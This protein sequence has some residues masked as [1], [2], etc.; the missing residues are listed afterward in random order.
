MRVIAAAAAVLIM[1]GVADARTWRVR[2]GPEAEQELQTALIEARPGDTVQLGRGRIELTSGLS[3]D[4]DRVTIRGEGHDETILSFSN[5][6]RGAEGLLVTSNGV[7]LRDFAVENARG[8]GIKARDCQGITFRR[9]RAEWTNGPDSN[10]GAYGLYPVNCSD[11]LIVDSIARGASDAGIYVGQ[12]R[13]IIVRNNLAEFN[14]AGIEIENS[15]NADVFG[16]TAR[17]NTGGVLVFDLPDLPQMGGHSVRVFENTISGN[18]TANFAPAGNIVA[19][20]PA[21]TG[22]LIM[23]NRDVHV[24]DNEIGENGTA[25]VIVTSYRAEF[26]DA[27]YN[28]LPRNIMIRDNRF[29]NAGFSPTGDIAA[30]AQAGVP[31]PDVLWDGATLYSVGGTPRNEQVRIVVQDNRST[32]T[33]TAS[34]LSLGLT[35]AGSPYTEAAP[36]PTFPPLMALAEPERVEIDD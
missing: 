23:A 4:V 32:R 36:D 28:P 18:N 2:P 26:Q 20:V 17:F 29:G 30:L 14:V 21:G 8:D 31:M 10:N 1:V 13:N 9:V 3:L 22:V 24:F 5:Q 6:R 25:N 7:T 11:V 19:S 33:G 15:Y 12:S 16:N 27:R 35:V 34:F